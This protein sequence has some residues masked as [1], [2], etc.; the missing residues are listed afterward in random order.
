M[1]NA[2]LFYRYIWPRKPLAVQPCIETER[3]ILREMRE[4]DA[5]A[6]FAMDSDPAVHT[7]LGN[8]P[9]QAI[10]QTRAAIAYLQQQ[11]TQ[12][13]IGRW[14][15]IEKSTGHFIGWSG[16]KFIPEEENGHSN[17]YD[18]GYRFSPA[19]W[20]KG[21]ATEATMA[22]LRHGFSKLQLDQIH[23]AAHA[24][25]KASKRVL[26]KCGLVFVNQFYWKDSLCDWFTISHRSTQSQS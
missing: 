8:Q 12:Y 19:Y 9:V 6:F 7:F 15:T 14:A 25:N 4:E 26:E 20:G 21:Y 5:P 10:D 11:Y 23:A 3:L 16:L 17:Y 1:Q 18:I 2:M 24:G 22:A 13:G